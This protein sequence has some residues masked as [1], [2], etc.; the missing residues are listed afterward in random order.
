MSPVAL[1]PEAN[2]VLVEPGGL[3]DPVPVDEA[4]PVP[5]KK[6]M[7]YPARICSALGVLAKKL[8]EGF[9]GPFVI[10]LNYNGIF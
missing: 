9:L 1:F 3:Y 5:E 2:P 6:E 4:S 7:F 10:L 8:N